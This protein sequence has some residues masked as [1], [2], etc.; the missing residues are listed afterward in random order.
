M[1]KEG[2]I[3]QGE[4]KKILLLC[5]DIR[6]TSGIATVARETIIGT[7][8]HFNWVNLG[9]AIQHPDSGKKLDISQDTNTHI[10]IKDASVFIYPSDGYGNPQLIRQLIEIEE[11]DAL[12]IF[13]DP[14]YW[15]WLFQIENEIRRK[16]P[17][18]YLNIWDDYP[19]PLYNEAYYESCDGLMAISKQTL[20]INKIVLGD[21]VKNKVLDYVPHG[22]NNK[23]FFPVNDDVKLKE[24]I[25]K[26]TLNCNDLEYS[27]D[28]KTKL[29][30]I[31]IQ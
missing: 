20:N 29:D 8:H 30:S 2:Y 22:I 17:I 31:R 15:T 24:I 25:D 28:L 23:L 19:A 3:P 12:M 13:T 14:R 27:D 1:L 18:I 6:F 10:G 7:A 5:D 4:R 16:I 21:K 9:A 11:P 26:V